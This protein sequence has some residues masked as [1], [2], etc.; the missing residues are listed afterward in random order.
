MKMTIKTDVIVKMSRD[1]AIALFNE[2]KDMYIED[3]VDMLPPQLHNL[4][5]DLDIITDQ[6]LD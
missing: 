3:G 5:Y 2:L 4:M 6:L 1:E